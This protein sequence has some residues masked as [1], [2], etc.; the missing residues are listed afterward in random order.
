MSDQEQSLIVLD[1]QRL[2]LLPAML[3]ADGR[4]NLEVGELA[5]KFVSEMFHDA[6]ESL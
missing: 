6:C 1:I 3:Y 2:P 5:D 4:A